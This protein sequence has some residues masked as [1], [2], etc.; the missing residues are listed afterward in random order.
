MLPFGI[1]IEGNT[2]GAVNFDSYVLVLCFAILLIKLTLFLLCYS[3]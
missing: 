1:D 2:G 3:I